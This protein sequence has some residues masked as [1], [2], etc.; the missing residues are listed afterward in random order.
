MRKSLSLILFITF[1][2]FL[3][4]SSFAQETTTTPVPTPTNEVLLNKSFP[5][6]KSELKFS[7]KGQGNIT[8]N[9]VLFDL[10]EIPT[11]ARILD[12]EFV[13]TQGNI[14]LGLVKIIDKRSGSYIDSISTGSEGMKNTSRID[15]YIKEWISKPEN[16]LGLILQTEGLEDG[17]IIT[18]TLLTF[19]IEYIVPDSTPPQI[20]KLDLKVVNETTIKIDWETNEPVVA[21]AEYG[22]TSN[23]DKQTLPAVEFTFNGSFE[24]SGLGPSV[25]YHLLFTAKDPSGNITKSTNT[26]FSTNTTQTISPAIQTEGVLAPRIL[27]IEITSQG[28]LPQVDLAWSKSESS[29]FDGYILYRN[30][31][32]GEF[33]EL[34]RLDKSVTRYSDTKVVS[35]TS[36]NYYVVTYLGTQQSSRSP[37]Q[38]ANVQKTAGVLGL[39]SIVAS[40]N[41]SIGIFFILAGGLIILGSG[42]FV[43]KKIRANIAYNQNLSRPSR[44]HNYLHDPDYY[45]TGKFEESVI[46]NARD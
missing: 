12:T 15:S 46:E 10:K 44:L 17:K 25:T 6:D 29:S 3:V 28:N 39:E 19:N 26:T 5:A 30:I 42:Y 20:T 31:G 24:I 38:S 22:K 32:D 23:Y 35:G 2:F 18:L 11:N 16:N 14:S 34:A 4:G 1:S 13:Y 33:L 7:G 41:S 21:F 43:N 36:Y 27:N 40:N 9:E 37:I 45:T 8:T